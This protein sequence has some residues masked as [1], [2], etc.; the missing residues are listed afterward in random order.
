MTRRMTKAEAKAWRKRWL[1]VN[2]MER[3]ELRATPPAV[4]LA[5]LAALMAS[6][7]SFGW[8]ESLREGESE[9]RDRWIRLREAYRG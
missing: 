7:R 6:V 4:K 2:D 3:E 9:V 1:L 8:T 5:Q